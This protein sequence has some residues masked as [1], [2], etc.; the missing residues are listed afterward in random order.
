M[1]KGWIDLL[2]KIN[3]WLKKLNP[4]IIDW[5]SSWENAEY[6]HY[7]I[8]YDL[9]NN[10]LLKDFNL[11]DSLR[12]KLETSQHMTAT[13]FNNSL[14]YKD[15]IWESLKLELKQNNLKS[16]ICWHWW[17][18]LVEEMF[19]DINS[20]YWKV[21]LSQ[22]NSLFR[23]DRSFLRVDNQYWNFWVLILN[24]EGKVLDIF[25]YLISI[26]PEKV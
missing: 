9:E 23:L 24:K 11:I 14:Y 6:V 13:W 1:T 10:K 8:L 2:Q 19:N 7:N 16:L 25:D 21:L 18:K 5:L 3:K 15:K 26:K 20:D 22:E 12:Y 4:D 17:N